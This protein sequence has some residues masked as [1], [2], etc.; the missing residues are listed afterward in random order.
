LGRGGFATVLRCKRRI[1]GETVAIKVIDKEKI[2]SLNITERISNEIRIHSRISHPNIVEFKG[3][4]ED[5]NYLYIVLEACS[6]GNLYR[7][8]KK[9]SKFPEKTVSRIMQQLLAALSYLHDAGI[10]HRDLKLSNIVLNE[11]LDVKIW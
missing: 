3:S 4:F 8:L 9:N 2:V 1:T 7:M 6:H 11:N 10:V 5:D